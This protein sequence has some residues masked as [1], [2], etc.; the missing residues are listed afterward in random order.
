MCSGAVCCEATADTNS[1]G[2]G[3]AV[4]AFQGA[5]SDAGVHWQAAVCAVIPCGTDIP[6]KCLEY[7][8]PTTQLKN[9]R[10]DM[11]GVSNNAPVPE[12][13]ATSNQEEQIILTPASSS[14]NSFS[15]SYDPGTGAQLN[16]ETRDFDLSSAVLYSR[17]YA[18]DV[19][20]YKCPK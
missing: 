12:V 6:S 3:F 5:D 11:T 14:P 17:N 8:P 15:Y 7:R 18:S 20:P 4:G 16:V 2:D 9:L 10:L 1:S 19:L 13:V